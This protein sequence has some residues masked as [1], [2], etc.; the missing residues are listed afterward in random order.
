MTEVAVLGAGSWG[1]VLA[2]HLAARGHDVVLWAYEPEVADAINRTHENALYLPRI[3]LHPSLRAT[4]DAVDAV[5]GRPVVLSVSPS[6]RVRSVLTQVAGVAA[7]DAL[8][9]GASKGIETDTLKRMSEVCA[10]EL[11]GRPYVILSGPSFAEE[12]AQRQPTAVVAASTSPAAAAQAQ[13]LLTSGT[14]R[15]YTSGDVTGTELAGS[16]KNV[17]AIAAGMCDGLG[18]GNNP[19]AALITR[20]LAEITRLGVALGADPRTFSGLAGVGDLVL[21][22][23]GSLSRNRALGVA[24]AQGETLSDFTASH[25][26]VVEGVHTA[27]VAVRMAEQARVEMPIAAKVAQ[28]LFEAKPPRQAIME[29][30]ERIPK[31]E[32]WT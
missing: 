32:Q 19:R 14:F 4:A 17:I 3:Q 25:H 30:M 24:L 22:T 15:V 1:T 29:L 13:Q 27:R 26:A 10:E 11:P 21:T 16:F 8:L 28:C 20:G 31:P 23:C 2:D 6:Q 12:V 5:R 9:I 18:L 7:P